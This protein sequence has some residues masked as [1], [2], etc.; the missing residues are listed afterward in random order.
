MNV[1]AGSRALEEPLVVCSAGAEDGPILM[2][3][4]RWHAG[5]FVELM[6]RGQR[7][8]A[9]PFHLMKT[10]TLTGNPPYSIPSYSALGQVG[11]CLKSFGETG[12][13]V[14][15]SLR[16]P[17][18]PTPSPRPNAPTRRSPMALC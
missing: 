3:E 17:I 8:V 18:A 11:E 2:T 4:P 14:G 9:A 12:G 7:R 5:Q 15:S 10:A 6:R 16:L 1:L 13:Y